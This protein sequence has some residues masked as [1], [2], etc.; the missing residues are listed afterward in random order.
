MCGKEVVRA[1]GNCG[2]EVVRAVDNCGKDVVKAIYIYM[3]Q[4]CGKGYR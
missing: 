4:R 1:V 2:K 3:W